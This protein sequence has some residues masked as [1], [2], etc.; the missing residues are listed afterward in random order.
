M[1]QG[2]INYIKNA[3]NSGKTEAE[4]KQILLNDSR[5]EAEIESIFAS[6]DSPKQA[7]VIL[8][9]NK[10]SPSFS[11][12][13]RVTSAER[14]MLF[15]GLLI[16]LASY[17]YFAVSGGWGSFFRFLVTGPIYGVIFIYFL[18][19]VLG[20]NKSGGSEIIYDDSKVTYSVT[21]FTLAILTSS[22]DCGDVEG[23]SYFI[24][25]LLYQIKRLVFNL[26]PVRNSACV[27]SY[28]YSAG[29]ASLL[30][31]L[32]TA[33]FITHI[34]YLVS[35]IR[36]IAP[37]PV[38]AENYKKSLSLTN[39]ILVFST[40]TVVCLV[41]GFYGQEQ[42]SYFKIRHD[43]EEHKMAEMLSLQKEA[44]AKVGYPVE[45][46][47]NG[48][49]ISAECVP[50]SKLSLVDIVT[51]AEEMGLQKPDGG[52]WTISFYRNSRKDD[53][54]DTYV[55]FCSWNV[56]AKIEKNRPS[57]DYRVITDGIVPKR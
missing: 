25:T 41:L 1:D 42:D 49:G 3:R 9:D 21:F 24:N 20:I 51:K 47:R 55:D 5:T 52:H 15:G 56:H 26:E 43:L 30:F 34:W 12:N 4:I 32:G 33:L 38:S 53:K 57:V 35:F 28:D 11:D 16:L 40:V 8:E 45:F 50:V 19:R 6:I 7:T 2:L 17:F 29:A 44:S 18:L 36:S 14:T 46:E 54:T 39:K 22:G 10:N 27:Q 23:G 13:Y 31:Y 37:K 48:Y